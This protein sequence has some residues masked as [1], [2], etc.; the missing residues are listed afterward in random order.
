M[1]V[2]IEANLF[3]ILC[4]CFRDGEAFT[5]VLEYGRIFIVN[6][7]LRPS[8]EGISVFQRVKSLAVVDV[9]TEY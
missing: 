1:C 3:H 9:A 2:F 7:P 8:E 4:C 6:T 5:S